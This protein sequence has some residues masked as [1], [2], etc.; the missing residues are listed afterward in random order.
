MKVETK[1]KRYISCPECNEGEHIIEHLIDRAN[2]EDNKSTFGP[3]HCHNMSCG[4]I[5]RGDVDKDG[6]VYFEPAKNFIG[7]N[8]SYPTLSLLKLN[9]YYLVVD[10]AVIGEEDGSI[11]NWDYFFHSHQCP[12]NLF[13]SVVAVFD[14]EES[15]PH[16]IMRFMG[17]IRLTDESQKKLDTEIHKTEDLLK[18]FNSD[19]F[20]LESEWPQ[21]NKGVLH[22]IVAMRSKPKI[23]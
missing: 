23:Q 9:D 4:F 1:I 22:G 15:D 18:L 16:G 6:N 21:E 5:F 13:R 14:H 20:P 12:S 7:N 19:G 3:W 10:H 2:N 8:R 11:E 17:S